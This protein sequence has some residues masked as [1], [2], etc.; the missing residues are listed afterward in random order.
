MQTCSR[1][2]TILDA[3]MLAGKIESELVPDDKLRE[4]PDVV[5]EF[6]QRCLL[7]YIRDDQKGTFGSGTKRKQF[8]TLTPYT[9]EEASR[10]L[11]LKWPWLER[12]HVL[13]LDPK[14]IS[15]PILGPRSIAGGFGIEYVLP[16][17]FPFDAIANPGYDLEI[18]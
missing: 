6:G 11:A 2:A 9:P 14:K 17:G 15:R 10:W 18:S 4:I 1:T 5:E 13:I 3:K 12:R 7:R 8:V 16:L